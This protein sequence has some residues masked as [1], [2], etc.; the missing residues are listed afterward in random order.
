MNYKIGAYTF[1]RDRSDQTGS[2]RIRMG[3]LIKYD[4]DFEIA[5]TG[6]KYD[7]VV[8]QKYYFYDY[9][10][11]FKGIKILDICD[12]DWL[13]GS[14]N[15][16]IIRLLAD[17]DAVVANTQATANYMRK[18]TSKPVIVIPDRHDMV[19]LKYK[20]QHKGPAKSVV[21]FGYAHNAHVL[22][23]YIP[24]LMELGLDLTM[25]TDKFVTNCSHKNTEFKSHEHYVKWQNLDQANLEILQHDICLLPASRRPQ[26]QY[27]SNNKATH[28]WAIGM[29]VAQW[30]DDLD[31]FVEEE[32]RIR[33]QEEHYALT[34]TDYDCKQSIIEY[35]SLINS[36][37]GAK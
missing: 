2:A 35:K 7:V 24:K 33:D 26:D 25:L 30:G 20:K 36:L 6:V 11:L 3:N 13:T 34:R 5:I 10:A 19:E 17:I 12:P 23:P 4:S 16:E 32:N 18:L 8:F 37:M 14:P 27:K 28:A 9:A 1:D 29:P 21:W 22:G 15:I 31:K